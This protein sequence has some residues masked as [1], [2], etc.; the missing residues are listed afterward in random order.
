MKDFDQKWQRLTARARTAP[1]GGD[2]A[3]PYGF[4]TRVAAQA[5]ALRPG[6]PGALFEKFALRG[7]V[8]AFALSLASMA[9]SYTALTAEADEDFSLASDPVPELLDIAS[10]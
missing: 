5:F 4:A 9:Y 8:A 10:S 1:A 3:A 6:G 7:L 2:E